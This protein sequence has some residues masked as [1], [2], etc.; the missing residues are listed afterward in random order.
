[1]RHITTLPVF[2]CVASIVLGTAYAP[3]ASAAGTPQPIDYKAYDGWNAIRGLRLS[4]DGR[5]MAYAL[6]P[7]DG[8]PT[9]VVRNL[10]TGAE[11]TQVRGSAP[12]FTADGKF[13]VYTL[14]ALKKDADAARKAKKTDEQLPKNGLGILEVA[15]GKLTTYERV[16]S[17]QV[18]RDGSRFIAFLDELPLRASSAPGAIASPAPV[19]SALPIGVATGE[20]STA[21]TTAP[22][23]SP[24]PSAKA[25]KK[26]DDGANLIVRDLQSGTD[27]ALANVTEFALGDDDRTLG[28]ATETKD[29]KG[30]GVHVR[31]LA[32]GVTS[33]VLGG[34][35]RY[36]NLAT[37]RAGTALGFLSDARTY[38]QDVPHY[39]AYVV[40]LT[41]PTPSALLAVSDTTTGMPRGTTVSD[42]GT[43]VWS[44]DGKRMFLGV[45]AAP[46]PIPAGTPTPINVDLWTYRDT[47]LQSVQFHDQAQDRKRTDLGVYD[48]AAK[49]YVQLA[50]PA[51]RV[52]LT[53]ENGTTALGFD[54]R[55]YAISASWTGQGYTDIYAISLADGSRKR[56]ARKVS[57]QAFSPGG[58]YVVVWDEH[59]RKWA[60]VRTSDG[61]RTVL[62][63]AQTV[64]F[65]DETDDHPG[66]QPPYGLGGFIAGD[67]SVIVY[68]RFDPWLVDLATGFAKNLTSGVGRKTSV[69]YS[70]MNTDPDRTALPADAPLLL[71]LTDQVTYASG[72]AS[73]S[74]SGGAPKTLIRADKFISNSG[75][76]FGTV[77]DRI[78]PPIKARSADRL[79][80]TQETYREAR[81]VWVSDSTFA[82]PIKSSNANPQLVNYTWGHEQLISYKTEQGMPL[83]AVLLTPD[84]FDP[85]KKYPMLVYFYEKWT[86]QYHSFYA[87]APRYPTLSR[88]VSN[89]YLVLLP[90]VVYKV[91]HPGKSALEA[92]N[93]AV[94]AVT[95][96]GFVD[97]KHVGIAGH[98]W[99]AYQINYMITQTDRFRAVEAGAAVANMTSAYGG[100]RL[101]SGNVRESQY[102]AGQSRIGA[103]P[104]DRPDL[105]LENSGLFHIKNIHTPYLTMH[106]DADG[107]VPFSQGVE[108]MTAMRRLN[109]PAYMFTF[110]GKDHNLRDTP[111]D[112]EQLKFW[113]VHFDEWFDYWLKG[114]PRP[115]WF[116][117]TEYLHRGERDVRPLYGE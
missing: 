30:D 38:A 46:T 12:R 17:A 28:F 79:A 100:I 7:E 65:A 4:D 88:Y 67:R 25:D 54:N 87:P 112:R 23:P 69:V 90:D 59:L 19:T 91:G 81:D 24:S 113:A 97:T 74:L 40:D 66:P 29:G 114:A 109:K 108:F 58:A 78:A 10:T 103:S 9:L 115:S 60:S 94:D 105:Y 36:K 42:D 31:D 56:I 37:A 2:L 35:G 89:G 5:T 107:A 95:K 62:A 41:T 48:L 102:E 75:A 14:N 82:H 106:N 110:N 44:K 80:F 68:D 98:S 83:R 116:D 99:A 96:R 63:A 76:Q 50:N 111:A 18:A 64:T 34:V 71:S 77:H 51:Q 13:V 8:D 22:V 53:N 101:E 70:V 15:T 11:T 84:G 16:K 85:H 20:P 26:K 47:R 92:I 39:D 117:G 3:P 32:G 93:A 86:D 55:P 57:D 6:T 52:V 1:M 104:W 49:R 45:A 73:G 61:Q 27:L 21:P 43:T 33:D 72:F